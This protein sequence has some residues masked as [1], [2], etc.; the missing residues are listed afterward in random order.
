M[1]S[2]VG[3]LIELYQDGG[4]ES[5]FDG[6]RRFFHWRKLRVLRFF[7]MHC[8]PHLGI[9]LKGESLTEPIF[10]VG[11]PRSGT[12]I[13]TRNLASHPDVAEWSEAGRIWDPNYSDPTADHVFTSSDVTEQDR[14][15][16]RNTFLTY[17][18][19]RGKARFVN[20]HPRNT[21]RIEYI[22]EL[23]PDAYFIHMVRHPIGPVD[24]MM[25]RSK[26]DDRVSHPY[27]RFV[28]PPGWREDIHKDGLSQFA[29]SWK[30]INEFL[31]DHHDERFYTVTYEALCENSV[32]AFNGVC[33]F[34]GLDPGFRAEN[35]PRDM[36]NHNQRSTKNLSL[37]ERDRLWSIVEPVATEFD[38]EKM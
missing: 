19:L 5:I 23:F 37:E 7:S 14:D 36:T 8:G 24:S 26:Q 15:R 17:T 18:K 31:L 38:Y 16:I 34:V 12:S 10:I 20:K 27:G 35:L 32:N 29:L 1:S 30:K 9:W 25:R 21:L 13:F 22:R 28:K 2:S 3:R 4:L 6:I 11:C 33:E